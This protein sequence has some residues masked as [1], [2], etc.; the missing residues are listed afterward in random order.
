MLNHGIPSFGYRIEAPYT[1]GKIDVSPN[2]AI[3]GP[4]TASP[5]KSLEL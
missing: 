2:I 4:F 3:T 5:L 1:S